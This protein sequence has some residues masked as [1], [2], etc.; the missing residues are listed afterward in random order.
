MKML[1][2]SQQ[3]AEQFYGIHKDRPFFKELV[4]F[5]VS[6]PVVVMVLEGPG[7][8]EK[9]VGLWALRILRRLKKERFVRILLNR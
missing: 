7:A 4:S 5:M 6:G 9:I 2:L 1:H 8:I 3:Q